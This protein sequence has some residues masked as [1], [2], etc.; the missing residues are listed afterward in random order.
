MEFIIR[1]KVDDSVIKS[2]EK[3]L[4]KGNNVKFKIENLNVEFVMGTPDAKKTVEYVVTKDG[5][6]NKLKRSLF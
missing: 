1:I 3:E 2:I 6:M 5:L 4:G